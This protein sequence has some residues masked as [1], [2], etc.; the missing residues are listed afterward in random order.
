MAGIVL[1]RD[2]DAGGFPFKRLAEQ[3]GK[4]VRNRGMN[5]RHWPKVRH[6]AT[7]APKPARL[8][9]ISRGGSG[10]RIGGRSGS[11]GRILSENWR[12][13]CQGHQSDPKFVHAPQRSH[14]YAEGEYDVPRM[15]NV[16]ATSLRIN[17]GWQTGVGF[18]SLE[19]T[20]PPSRL[21]VPNLWPLAIFR[22]LFEAVNPSRLHMSFVGYPAKPRA[23][24]V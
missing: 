13:Q 16:R 8:S 15:T 5:F 2:E 1:G 4:R 21:A 14:D 20:S 17:V 24:I 3:A 11:G 19:R 22:V 7:R 18:L 10:L 6:A 23:A 12:R 9:G